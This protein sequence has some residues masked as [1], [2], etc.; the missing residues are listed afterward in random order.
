MN[1]NELVERVAEKSYLTRAEAYRAVQAVFAVIEGAAVR[2][3]DIA[4]NRFGKFAVKSVASR[5]G[6][7]P[8]TGEWTHFRGSRKLTF[9]AARTLKEQ[10]KE[11]R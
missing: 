11:D 8:R 5:E 6:R 9:R 1:S 3:E 10:L 4:I 2:G 7:H